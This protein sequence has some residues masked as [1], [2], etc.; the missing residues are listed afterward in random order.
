M[1]AV[2]ACPAHTLRSN[3]PLLEGGPEACFQRATGSILGAD[4][5]LPIRS[6]RL[7]FITHLSF[8]VPSSPPCSPYEEGRSFACVEGN[9]ISLSSCRTVLSY[10]Y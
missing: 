8:R 3:A 4:E 2:H 9:R 1:R 5:L 7:L 6:P 10:Y